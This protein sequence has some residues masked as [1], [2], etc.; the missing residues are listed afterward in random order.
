MAKGSLK[1]WGIACALV[2]A[3][4]MSL[5]AQTSEPN[6]TLAKSGLV[7]VA[8]G[9]VLVTTLVDT[10]AITA[11]SDVRIEVR[12]AT[13]Q[14]RGYATGRLSRGKPVRLRV[15]VP[16]DS[17]IQQFRVIVRITR[18]VNGRQSAPIISLE[19]IDANSLTILTRP[20]CVPPGSGENAQGN[21]DGGWRVNVLTIDQPGPDGTADVE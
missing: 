2:A 5:A 13:D 9:H 15:Q 19:D 12:D 7:S 16:A 4:V 14:K 21:C 11:S 3:T 1:T 18:L 6:A 17:G 20:S 10:G 8:P